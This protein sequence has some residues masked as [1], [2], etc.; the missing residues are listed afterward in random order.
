MSDD[1]PPTDPTAPDAASTDPAAADDAATPDPDAAPEHAAGQAAG[2]PGAALQA[3]GRGQPNPPAP[4]KRTGLLLDPDDLREYVGGLLR[5]FL[6]GYQV[7][8]FGNFTFEHDGAHVFVTIGGSPIGPQVGVFSVTN[9]DLDLG[10]DLA[11]FIA[12]T[13]HRLGFGALSY[14]PES[15][16]VWLRHS[17]LGTMLDG[18]ELQAA[19]AAIASTA[20]Q[21]DDHI[22]DAFG[23]RLFGEEPAD[24]QQA[25][26]PPEPPQEP[27]SANG[28]L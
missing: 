9:V 13:N 3:A 20:A 4:P 2:G 18:P 1:L 28:Y 26:K 24:V 22:A 10:P 17:L 23:G 16:T 19:V 25:T 21:V 14:D 12:T 7:D 15:R 11:R 8:A 6:G 5:A 27:Y